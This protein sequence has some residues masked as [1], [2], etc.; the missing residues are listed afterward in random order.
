MRLSITCFDWWGA[1]GNQ[2]RV[3]MWQ[4]V[5]VEIQSGKRGEEKRKIIKKD[6]YLSKDLFGEGKKKKKDEKK[7]DLPSTH[8]RDIDSVARSAARWDSERNFPH[9]SNLDNVTR[10]NGVI[11]NL[12]A[13]VGRLLQLRH[14]NHLVLRRSA[15]RN[16]SR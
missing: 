7:L 16:R 14:V 2:R 1:A 12:D 9:A 10:C 4:G 5:C 13:N 3:S 15:C 6:L 11:T 8:F